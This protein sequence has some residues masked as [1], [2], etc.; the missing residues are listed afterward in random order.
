M[1]HNPGTDA[2]R[3]VLIAGMGSELQ[4]DDAFGL[5]VVRRLASGRFTLPDTARVFEAGTA[6]IGLV[7]ELLDGYDAL[8]VVDAVD[9]SGEPGRLYVLEVDATGSG[10]LSDDEARELLADM[11]YTVPSRVL[12]LARALGVLPK[13]VYLVGCQPADLDLGLELS[14]VV[15]EMVDRTAETV[16]D[17][18]RV[19]VEGK[20][21]V[22]GYSTHRTSD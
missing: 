16:V 14:P 20:Q 15:A 1:G 19:L 11:H 4:R 21:D 2:L 3:R 17:M 5:A 12:V 18:T 10:D 7:Q 22:P 13:R 8:I 6:G 9:R